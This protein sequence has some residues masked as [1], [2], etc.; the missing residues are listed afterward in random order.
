MCHCFLCVACVDILT[1]QCSAHLAAIGHACCEVPLGP[2][3]HSHRVMLR[4]Y[5]TQIHA[6]TALLL[7]S[8]PCMHML[9]WTLR[10]PPCWVG[11]VWDGEAGFAGQQGGV[12]NGAASWETRAGPGTYPY[13]LRQFALCTDVG[14]GEEEECQ[15]RAQARLQ[16]SLHQYTCGSGSWHRGSRVRQ[17]G[18]TPSVLVPLQ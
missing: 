13:R 17:A 9:H 4:L 16:V 1:N 15:Q 18:A 3:L 2:A 7:P 6:T 14:A 12:R 11:H 10:H 8:Q 5:I